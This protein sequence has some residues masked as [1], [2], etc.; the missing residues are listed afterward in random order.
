MAARRLLLLVLLLVLTGCGGG[1]QPAS[2]PPPA[3]PTT[4]PTPSASARPTTP[5]IVATQQISDRQ[6]DLTVASPA[7]GGEV[8]VRLL[9]PKGFE[10]QPTKPRPVLYLLHGCCDTYVS[11]T[12][13]TDIEKLTGDSDLLVV[14]PDGG[15]VGFYSD[16][17]T[18]PAWERFHLTELPA[19]LAKDY[20]AG[21][22]MAIAGVSMG[23]LGAIGYA[24]RNPGMFRAVASFSGIVHT[25]ISPET[26]QGY[27]GLVQSEGEDGYALWGDPETDQAIWREHN[28]YDLVDRLKST[29]LYVSCGNGES[30]PL[31]AEGTVDSVE[32]PLRQQNEALAK[33]LKKGYPEATVHLYGPGTHNWVYWE[34]ELHRAWPMITK[35]LGV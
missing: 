11:W 19:L 25:R 8:M 10:R 12:R 4:T 28:P 33:R 15:P 30:G 29:P 22:P 16:W 6:V 34:R 23:G 13:S 35:A 21:R 24:A 14:M 31:D 9:L 7:V 5:A 1:A 3:S 2:T 32:R 17:K 20:G 18:G 27:I 26:S